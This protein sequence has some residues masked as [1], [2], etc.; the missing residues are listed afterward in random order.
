MPEI[1]A[2]TGLRGVAAILVV[3]FHMRDALEARGLLVELPLL[4]ARFIDGSKSVDVFFVLSGFIMALSYQK[5][6]ELSVPTNLYI[7]FLSRR[8][9][10]V[11]PLHFFMLAVAV[12][13]VVAARLLNAPTV[14]G[15]DRFS[16]AELVPSLLLVQAW[17]PFTQGVGEWNPPAWSISIEA[18]AYLIFP[19]V[20]WLITRS[21]VRDRWVM[22]LIAIGTG[23]MLNAVT[24]WDMHGF[25]ACARGLS[26]FLLG[27]VTARFYR[28]RVGTW[29]QGSW[30]S[31][32]SVL[33]LIAAFAAT[34]VAGF[35]IALASA[36]VLLAL[37][38]ENATSKFFSGRPVYFLGE[39]SYSIYLGHFIFM[40]IC[41]RL[42]SVSWMQTSFLSA[43]LG[44]LCVNLLIISFATATYYGVERPGRDLL[45][46][47]RKPEAAVGATTVG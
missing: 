38:G 23:S 33:G 16:F 12:A 1:R 9:A 4:A 7:R 45:A 42:V 40:S 24:A 25:G 41:W 44:I 32:I 17:G 15:L 6:F 5:W 39:I 26:E 37:C 34:P 30:G 35:I 47:R 29:L 22:L 31:A 20:M 13:L 14:N 21:R 19:F 11:Y 8:L 28:T 36:P 46:G 27:C 43:T 3:W 10:R 2:L 18:L